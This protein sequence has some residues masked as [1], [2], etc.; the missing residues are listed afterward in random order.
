MDAERQRPAGQHHDSL[1]QIVEVGAHRAPP[2]DHQE[3][4]TV[5]VVE[6]ALGTAV[7]VGRHRIDALGAE[8]LL[9]VGHDALDLGDRPV[10]DVGAVAGGDRSHVRGGLERGEGAP[11]EVED[12]ERHLRGR[13]GQ[14]QRHHQC[15]QRG[16]L[17][18]QRTT[19]DAHVAAGARQVEDQRFAALFEGH[20]DRAERH[21][22]RS[23]STPL[24]RDQT[25]ARIDC[26]IGH[27]S[28]Q[29]VGDVQWRQPDPVGRQAMA[30]HAGDRDVELGHRGPA[31]VARLHE[32]WRRNRNTHR[33]SVDAELGRR[34]ER[35]HPDGH[36]GCAG[37]S[38]ERAIE[39]PG[40]RRS[41]DIR[42]PEP[43]H[44]VGGRLQEAHAWD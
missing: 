34:G 1:L 11:T 37:L 7:S 21:P 39:P 15:P 36:R 25:E 6:T 44:R 19:D 8:V 41:S 17:A 26:Q 42:G 38:G 31:F 9:A 3:D 10:D 22:Q 28:V 24:L 18:R 13:V 4:V 27:Q 2:V 20:V 23:G 16:G 33:G 43:G 14:R 12:V 32:W 35:H 29:G 40:R 5:A 30:P